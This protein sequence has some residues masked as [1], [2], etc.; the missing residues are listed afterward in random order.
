MA[1]AGP[2]IATRSSLCCELAP[3]VVLV[4]LLQ[5]PPSNAH[6]TNHFK[7]RDQALYFCVAIDSRTILILNY[8]GIQP[9]VFCVPTPLGLFQAAKARWR[10]GSLSRSTAEFVILQL[11]PEGKSPS[12]CYAYHF[13]RASCVTVRPVS[14]P[15]TNTSAP[16]RSDPAQP[17]YIRSMWRTGEQ[18]ATKVIGNTFTKSRVSTAKVLDR[19]LKL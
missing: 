3:A 13:P 15:N 18:L 14:H 11:V 4:L 5:I 10:A 12:P 6:Y 2:F 17:N 7:F 9:P 1:V 16:C 8:V 19:K